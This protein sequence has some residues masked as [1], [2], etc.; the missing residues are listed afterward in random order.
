V[1]DCASTYTAVVLRRGRRESQALGPASLEGAGLAAGR[2]GCGGRRRPGCASASDGGRQRPLISAKS[3]HRPIGGLVSVCD[4][5]DVATFPLPNGI[6]L[7]VY[8]IQSTYALDHR[9]FI[10]DIPGSR[11]GYLHGGR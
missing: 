4:N 2:G 10:I 7:R 11:F 9:Q 8:V 3:N 1:I 5:V 6:E